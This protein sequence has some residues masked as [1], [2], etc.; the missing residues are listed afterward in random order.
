MNRQYDFWVLDSGATIH[1][2]PYREKLLDFHPCTRVACVANGQEIYAEGYGNVVITVDSDGAYFDLPVLLEQV[3][4]IPD[5]S[6][7]FI[8]SYQLALSGLNTL[9]TANY[10]FLCHNAQPVAKGFELEG[11]YW[12]F[13]ISS[14]SSLAV[15]GKGLVPF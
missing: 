6:R 7:N 4:L 14:E 15:Q 5:L 2:T 9:T 12:I 11:C 8:S 1:A 10:A 3:W 13:A